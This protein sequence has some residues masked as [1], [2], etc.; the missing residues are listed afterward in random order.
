MTVISM[1]ASRNLASIPQWWWMPDALF[2]IQEMRA[3]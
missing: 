2:Q 1:L 3:V